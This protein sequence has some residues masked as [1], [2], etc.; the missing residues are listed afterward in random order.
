[1]RLNFNMR[2]TLLISMIVAG[3]IPMLAATVLI[4][5]TAADA[6]EDS[7]FSRL[8]ADAATRTS[9]LKTYLETLKE[10]NAGFAHNGLIRNAMDQFVVSFD[11][12]GSDLILFELESE[13]M[14]S[15]L[16]D[17]YRNEYEPFFKT[18]T[19]KQINGLSLLPTTTNGLAAQFT[20]MAENDNAVDDK[21]L[22]IRADN[23]TSYDRRHGAYHDTFVD[24]LERFDLNDILLVEPRDGTVVY[25]VEKK[26][27]FGTSLWNGPQQNS[28]LAV[29]ARKAMSLKPGE[30]VLLDLSLHTPAFNEPVFFVATPIYKESLLLGAA[31]FEVSGT[32]MNSIMNSSEGMGKTGKSMVLGPD[33]IMRTQSRF[34]ENNTV[35][36]LKVETEA[37]TLAL[38]GESGL[39]FATVGE[40]LS[41]EAFSPLDVDGLNWIVISRM[42]KD[43]ALESVDSLF[44]MS[45]II[46]A[47]SAC[48]V[49]LFAIL[50]CR[51]FHSMLGGDP[52]D[53]Q[54][55]AEDIGRGNLAESSGD[56]RSVGAYAALVK[57]RNHLRKVIA[58]ASTVA[59]AVRTGS[60]ALS[61][62]SAGLNL[63]TEQQ[64]AS[65]EE[66]A[67]S[68][69]Q[70][71]GTVKQNADNAKVAN[72]LAINTRERATKS[73]E[74]SDRA[75]QAMQEISSASERIADI[76]GVID[77]IAFQTNLLAL[78]AAV[79][80]A[81]AGEQGRGFAVVA[82]EV[83][84]LAGRSASAA[85]EIKDLIE[86]SVHK[87][88]DGTGLVRQSGEELEQIVKSIVE[89]T[90]IVGQITVASEE[91]SVGIEQI[92]QSLVHMDGVTQQN[93]LLVEQA[94]VTSQDMNTQAAALSSYI[95]YFHTDSAE[96]RVVPDRVDQERVGPARAVNSVA[97]E[98]VTMPS[99]VQR[100]TVAKPDT[101]YSAQPIRQALGPTSED[102]ANKVASPMTRSQTH[103][104]AGEQPI[105]KASGS[106]EFWDEF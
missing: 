43:E 1:M 7:T 75:V 97:R 106:D 77:E 32:K 36:E 53:I 18:R 8:E 45:I 16:T 93:A 55:F 30:S 96:G 69:E 60:K 29:A 82:S 78:N 9:F 84:Q 79:E 70:L 21:Q 23:G 62:G 39:T 59:E 88:H 65:L 41:L 22:L 14:N 44:M 57:M 105:I 74:V 103:S 3:V 86:D 89:L 49:A 80:A 102:M 25:S 99:Q 73:G 15:S 83:R 33:M 26:V 51:R 90:E 61:E 85:R 92:N 40:E 2:E 46:A 38:A 101:L 10:L 68:T 100:A 5:R 47:I 48:A 31:V 91:Q 28:S 81:R 66:T 35:L 67:S 72:A 19:G 63:R 87:V 11:T 27:D 37:G 76:I 12:L 56:E 17:F 34:H 71:T 64:A 24:V 98:P 42:S 94:S 104:S 20:Y 52:I 50:L 4:S 58:E 54:M 95:G 6:L 13:D